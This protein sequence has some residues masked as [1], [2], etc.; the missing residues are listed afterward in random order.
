VKIMAL[1]FLD[2][3]NR[4]CGTDEQVV[5]AIEY[6]ASFG[7]RIA[8]ASYGGYTY[9]SAEKAAIDASGL[10]L[11]AAAGNDGMDID[12]SPTY[13]AAYTSPNILTVASIDN[14]GHYSWFS[15]V[16]RTSVD[17]AAP[18]EDVL[19]AIAA[20]SST[21]AA[22]AF[23]NGTSFS[24]P[25]VTGV[26]ALAATARPA[27]LSN[28]IA[29]RDR[30]V[31]TAW[32]Q[33]GYY[34]ATGG[35]A[36]A[37][38]AIDAPTITAPSGVLLAPATLGTST[39]TTRVS[40]AAG[41]DDDGPIAKYQLEQRVNGA[42]WTKVANPAGAYATNR[43]LTIATTYEYR[44]IAWDKAGNS[45]YMSGPK[46]RPLKYED[47]NSNLRY[48]GTWYTSSSSTA[49]G[50]KTK[51]SKRAGNSVTFRFT[52]R[53][54]AY[55]APK[56]ASRGSVRIYIDGVYSKL[57][58]LYSSTSRARQVV[59]AKSWSSSAT[60]TIKLVVVGTAGHPRVDVDAFVVLR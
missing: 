18:G 38:Y 56:S 42:S 40:T 60:H 57:V 44:L 48:G 29:L 54:I 16:G 35:V 8:N 23:E 19:V 25:H 15:N 45:V 47:S 1:K 33:S 28:P 30:V 21:A 24:A 14:T 32:G 43:S 2:E 4:F 13:P 39:V 34:T 51:Y 7:V 22:W 53:G 10:L 58:S 55:A 9:S 17:L 46:L 12:Q 31:S 36:D 49:S 37:L 52:G 11:V 27:L 41:T 59:Y 5:A 3:A 6:A 50:G 20:T 26:A